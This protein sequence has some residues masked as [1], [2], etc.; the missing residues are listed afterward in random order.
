MFFHKLAKVSQNF[1]GAMSEKVV[2][3]WNWMKFRYTKRL[4]FQGF[5]LWLQPLMDNNREY[6]I[7][8]CDLCVPNA[9]LYQSELIPEKKSVTIKSRLIITIIIKCTQKESNL[10][11][12]DS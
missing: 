9:A 2:F 11:P 7:W 10:Q 4:L 5:N 1:L 8:T 3:Y 12:S 6:K